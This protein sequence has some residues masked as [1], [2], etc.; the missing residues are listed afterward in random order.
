[1]GRLTV[2]HAAVRWGVLVEPR[3]EALPEREGCRHAAALRSRWR[4]IRR[5]APPATGILE[6]SDG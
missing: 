2:V 5:A 4:L 6:K 3:S 1:L